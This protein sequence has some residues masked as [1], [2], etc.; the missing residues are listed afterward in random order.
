MECNVKCISSRNE[1]EKKTKLRWINKKENSFVCFYMRFAKSVCGRNNYGPLTTNPITII[2][3][4]MCVC[5]LRQQLNTFGFDLE[6]IH[7]KKVETLTETRNTRKKMVI[8]S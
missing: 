5:H 3:M 4:C 2:H 1:G 8:I 7:L 6:S